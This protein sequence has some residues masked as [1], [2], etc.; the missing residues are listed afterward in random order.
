[1]KKIGRIGAALLACILPA[2]IL[3]GCGGKPKKKDNPVASETA[4]ES[5][6]QNEFGDWKENTEIRAAIENGEFEK[7]KESIGR[8]LQ[9]KPKDARAHFLMGQCLLGEKNFNKARRSFET[10]VKLDPENRNFKRELGR[11]HIEM[12]ED[13]LA[14]DMPSEAVEQFKQAL[15]FDFQKNQTEEKLAVA[16]EKSA[17][18]LTRR[19]N[20]SDAEKLLREA[21]L[22]LPEQQVL[23]VRLARLLT[24]GDRL[25]E[26]ERLLKGLTESYPDY[27]HGLIAYAQLL[28][29]MGEIKSA[30]TILGK[31]LEIAPADPDALALK[32]VLNKDIP[33]VTP[34]APEQITPDLARTT[35]VELEKDRRYVEQR[36]VL[37]S[38]IKK[39]PGENWALLKLSELDEKLELYDQALENV[40]SYLNT[41]PDCPQGN[42]QLARILQNKGQLEDALNILN[43]LSPDYTDQE[44][45]LNEIGQV[46]A[47]MGRFEEARSSWNRVI[48]SDP[49]NATGLFNLGQLAMETGDP[50]G[51]QPLF[52]RAVKLEPFNAKFRYFAGLNLIQSGLKEQAHSFWASS[53]DYLPA[54]D[55]YSKRISNA[56]GDQSAAVQAT[57]SADSAMPAVHIPSSVIEEAPEDP[58]YRMA[59]ES[60][61][62][63]QF[64]EAIAGFKKVIEK[65]PTSFNA[66]MNLGKVYSV[67]GDA[68]QACALYL[69]ALKLSPKNIHAL[70]ALANAYSEIGMHSFAAEITSQAQVSHPGETEGFPA[71]KTGAAAIKNSPR[72]FQP[73]IKAFINEKLIQEAQA[74]MQSGVAE[75]NPTADMLLLQGEVYK[76]LGQYESALESYRK[77]LE[78]EP[79]NPTPFVKT[80]DLLVAAG[81]FTNAIT[82]YEKA[83]KAQFIDPDTM[84]IIVDRFKQLG[85]E[86]DAQKVIGR[87][88][89]MNLN[90]NQISKLEAH[91]NN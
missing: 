39:F 59:L 84:F 32:A 83:L 4:V 5:A 55:P 85:R 1:M 62:S 26:A 73:L 25:M 57:N 18:D 75:E 31:A 91:M 33:V 42:F 37:N 53:Q 78:L 77:A 11:C 12:G 86:A 19:G 51:A 58:D 52:E 14:Q 40:K 3:S 70:K 44:S 16:Y 74:I 38:L 29:R 41:M 10:A 80:G 27:E 9:S 23:K 76:E 49:E 82:E 43:R 2:M 30:S 47:K 46:Y 8:R 6:D 68:A 90:Q 87:L 21:S 61:R 28:Y 36:N 72:A 89:G 66:L 48:T 60:A 64:N 67:S 7:A 79:Q 15:E 56:L 65:D 20:H 69:K 71:Y 17:D 50:T 45:M 24:E 13:L 63:G 34:P 54:E 81:Q 88:R 22:L 35:L